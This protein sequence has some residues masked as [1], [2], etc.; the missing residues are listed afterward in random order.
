MTAVIEPKKRGRPEK[1]NNAEER[2]NADAE[3]KRKE[4]NRQRQDIELVAKHFKLDLSVKIP[5]SF[6]SKYGIGE[7]IV[8]YRDLLKLETVKETLLKQILRDLNEIGLIKTR[9]T[10]GATMKGA[11]RGKGTPRTGGYGSTEIDTIAGIRE[12]QEV[13]LGPEDRDTSYFPSG[14][15]RRVGPRDAD[16]ED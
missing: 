13:A 12:G 14:D 11:P 9:P 7:D 4:R 5:V 6:R 3:R 2:R 15:R 8:T 16:P 10:G 1:Y